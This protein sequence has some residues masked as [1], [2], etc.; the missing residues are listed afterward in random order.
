MQSR[1]LVGHDDI[2][3]AL[4][5]SELGDVK[6][7]AGQQRGKALGASSGRVSK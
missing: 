7:G 4:A 2:Q 3:Q 5:A 1:F 6:V